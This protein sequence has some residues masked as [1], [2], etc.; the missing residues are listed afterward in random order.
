MSNST[1]SSLSSLISIQLEPEQFRM[2][3]LQNGYSESEILKVVSGDGKYRQMIADAIIRDLHESRDG[4]TDRR[5]SARPILSSQRP[6]SPTR[7]PYV[8][9]RQVKGDAPFYPVPSM[10]ITKDNYLN[11]LVEEDSS[12]PMLS[13]QRPVSPTRTTPF[14]TKP[15]RIVPS[16]T[17][18]QLDEA[19]RRDRFAYLQ[20]DI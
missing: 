5:L 11:G 12:R 16:A 4:L 3:L 8:G 18:P 9:Q 17:R 15:R 6:V 1:S 13:S 7:T 14:S 2:W 10:G 19:S 20:T